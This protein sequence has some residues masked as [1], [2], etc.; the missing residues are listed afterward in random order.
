MDIVFEGS[1]EPEEAEKYLW[2]V[3]PQAGSSE[4]IG[5]LRVGF[6]DAPLWRPEE[7]KTAPL[8][9]PAR[10]WQEANGRVRIGY[11][12]FQVEIDVER[13]CVRIFRSAAG[14]AVLDAALR[15]A[16]SVCLPARGGVCLHG[17]G[18]SFAAG[19]V[20]FVGVSGAGKSTLSRLAPEPVLSDEF[21]GV[22]PS[23]S[24]GF[25]LASTP[26]WSSFVPAMPGPESV[27]LLALVELEKSTAFTWVAVAPDMRLRRLLR[28]LIAPPCGDVTATAIACLVK[29]AERVPMFRMGWSPA[30][31]PFERINAQLTVLSAE[32]RASGLMP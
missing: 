27:P 3:R 11:A 7:A 22:V 16:I 28:V 32:S 4:S 14:T 1:V 5:T 17:A 15:A 31:P 13:A 18:L 19:G 25:R 29:L 12:L 24:G 23:L 6:S 10:F 8:G 9:W 20:A 2:A 21:L 26:F 30:E